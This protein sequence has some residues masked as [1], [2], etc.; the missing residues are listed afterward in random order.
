MLRRR[1]PG[2]ERSGP[3]REAAERAA[4]VVGSLAQVRGPG[5]GLVTMTANAAR[6]GAPPSNSLTHVIRLRDA[7]TASR[8]R[9]DALHPPAP[10]QAVSWERAFS[11]LPRVSER[12]RAS[13]RRYA[14]RPAGL[15]PRFCASLA[16][17]AFPPRQLLSRDHRVS[18][19]FDCVTG[20]VGPARLGRAQC[21]PAPNE[22]GGGSPAV[23]NL[24]AG[25]A[26][27][28][29]RLRGRRARYEDRRK[30]ACGES[31]QRCPTR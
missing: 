3:S 8:R 19:R 18:V 27:D 14:T 13:P 16:G 11:P 9:H 10:M 28:P 26:D 25:H 12:Q 21:L 15:P 22:A 24:G 31:S 6:R 30:G 20:V 2:S 5:H 4:H 1:R 29:L 17:A 23:V 7:Q